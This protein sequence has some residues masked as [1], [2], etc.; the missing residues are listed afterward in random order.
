MSGEGSR[1]SAACWKKN[2]GALKC[3]REGPS[4]PVAVGRF[5]SI[6]RRGILDSL[7][8]DGQI[9][10][11]G[12]GLDEVELEALG[13]PDA[14]VLLDEAV[15]PSVPSRLRG[16]T[17]HVPILVLA[18]RPTAVYGRT[19]LAFGVSCLDW[20]KASSDDLRAAVL[21]THKG[22]ALFWA[23]DCRVEHR[24]ETQSSFLTERERA[25]LVHLSARVGY[26]EIGL[27]LGISVFTVKT[28]A[29]RLRDK[30]G[31]TSSRQLFDVPVLDS[32]LP[33]PKLGRRR[34]H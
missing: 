26:E 9:E 1:G 25:I 17:P 33:P 12:A 34:Q 3:H 5:S 14:A 30:L 20:E 24:P 6:V 4:V 19:L 23:S 13:R 28:H 2:S 21:N 31:A 27:R 18:H 16:S 15:V 32:P 11:L 29:A 7:Y 8:E 10:V 22:G